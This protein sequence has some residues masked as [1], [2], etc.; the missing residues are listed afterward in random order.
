LPT[1]VSK[2]AIDALHHLKVDVRFNTSVI[3]TTKMANGQQELSLSDGSKLTTEMYIPTFGLIP[4]S[5]YVPAK[6]LDPQGFVM[7]DE[8]LAV[9]AAK[10]V[11]AIGDVSDTEFPQ[12]LPMDR[13]SK[14]IAKAITSI[15]SNTP[16]APYKAMSTRRP[17]SSLFSLIHC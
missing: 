1:S 17:P 14:Y 11:W 6:F 13:Q 12:F 16:V 15:L 5:S 4:N 10:D 8:H 3:T 2:I 7:V 9:K